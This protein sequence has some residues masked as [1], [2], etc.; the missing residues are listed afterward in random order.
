MLLE[1]SPMDMYLKIKDSDS[2]AFEILNTVAKRLSGSMTKKS[3]ELVSWLR[4]HENLNVNDARAGAITELIP[5]LV[6]G[7]AQAA[8][9][10]TLLVETGASGARWINPV[11]DTDEQEAMIVAHLTLVEDPEVVVVAA[12][13]TVVVTWT[14][15]LADMLLPSVHTTTVGGEM[16]AVA[17]EVLTEESKKEY[18]DDHVYVLVGC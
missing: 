11:V 6:T 16:A 4:L 5:S 15:D 12:A 8:E 18:G 7:F 17:D 3:R 10:T 9:L 2:S 14:T 13:T 1:K